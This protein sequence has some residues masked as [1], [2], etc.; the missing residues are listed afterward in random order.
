MKFYEY[1][2]IRTQHTGIKEE[3]EIN[4]G[5][6]LLGIGAHDPPGHR[7]SFWEGGTDIA[8]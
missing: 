2:S 7:R 8:A 3:S 6:K 4:A 5:W 1:R